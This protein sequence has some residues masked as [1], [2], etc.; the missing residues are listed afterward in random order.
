MN[1]YK[2]LLKHYKAINEAC[3]ELNGITVLA[4]ENGAGKST[5]TRWLY[6]L[7]EGVSRYED[8]VYEDFYHDVYSI[9][10]DFR[11]ILRDTSL[12]NEE[13]VSLMNRWDKVSKTIDYG[14]NEDVRQLANE[15]IKIINKFGDYLYD[16]IKQKEKGRSG[17]SLIRAMIYLDVEDIEN[18]DKQQFVEKYESKVNAYYNDFV[19]KLK[20]RSVLSLFSYIR[21]HFDRTFKIPE[22]IEFFEYGVPIMTKKSFGH[23]LGLRRAIYIDTPMAVGNI[24]LEN[25]LWENLSVLL[26]KENNVDLD[27]PTRKMLKRIQHIIHGTIQVKEDDFETNVRYV[28]EDRLDIPL[29]EVATGIKSFAFIIRL[30]QNG[31]LDKNTLLIIDEPEAHLHPQWIVEYARILVL[32]E[33]EIGVHVLIASHNPDMVA[34]IQSIGKKEGLDSA[35]T[36]YQAYSSKDP[37][38][39]E[40]KKLGLEITEIFKS[41]NIALSRIEDYGTINNK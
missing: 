29:I 33:K 6:Y 27:V 17:K 4:G 34:A 11:M 20:N 41:F 24:G 32:L 21:Q 18:F 3:I 1:S 30:L 25:Q 38:E 5:I 9:L 35:I 16:D 13:L 22:S 2:F 36:F 19:K 28:R 14:T 37:Y 26:E 40:Y 12:M 8:F 10:R 7:V 23:L 39:Y 15:A 31:Y